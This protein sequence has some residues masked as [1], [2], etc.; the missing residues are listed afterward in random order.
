MKV[1]LIALGLG[2]A[3]LAAPTTEAQIRNGDFSRGSADWTALNMAK[4]GNPPACLYFPSAGVD[5][6]LTIEP[7][8][9]LGCR[10]SISQAVN[11]G[12]PDA[13]C[14]LQLNERDTRIG[15]IPGPHR[16]RSRRGMP[17]RG[18]STTS[19]CSARPCPCSA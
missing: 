6:V 2:L 14:T 5:S 12:R 8:W 17:P 18:E 4:P 10:V 7:G 11:C 9:P 3:V 1:R 19:P 13:D 15:F 16:G